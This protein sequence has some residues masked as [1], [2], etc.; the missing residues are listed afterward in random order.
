MGHWQSVQSGHLL[1]NKMR[2]QGPLLLP[3]WAQEAQAS[4]PARAHKQ[5]LR[6]WTELTGRLMCRRACMPASAG[7]AICTHSHLPAPLCRW[8]PHRRKPRA[9]P[10]KTHVAVAAVC[11]RAWPNAACHASAG[12]SPH[13]AYLPL[14]PMYAVTIRA[15][16]P[17]YTRLA[18]LACQTSCTLR[19]QVSKL[20]VTWCGPPATPTPSCTRAH[21]LTWEEMR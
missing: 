5:G 15:P 21:T 17:C 11:M 9:A 10:H 14:L 2:G 3:G 18:I 13:A 19:V 6:S 8:P 12:T 20:R 1:T 4:R 7:V 16:G